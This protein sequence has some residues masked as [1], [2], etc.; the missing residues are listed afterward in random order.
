MFKSLRPECYIFKPIEKKLS[1][2]TRKHIQNSNS[3]LSLTQNLMYELDKQMSVIPLIFPTIPIV[4]VLPL[5][6]L[7]FKGKC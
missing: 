5:K 7:K 3:F 2:L 6:F 1:Y 4:I